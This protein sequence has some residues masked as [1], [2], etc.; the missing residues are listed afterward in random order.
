MRKDRSLLWKLLFC[1]AAIL[2]FLYLICLDY[3]NYQKNTAPHQEN[4]TTWDRQNSEKTNMD[5]TESSEIDAVTDETETDTETKENGNADKKKGRIALCLDYSRRSIYDVVFPLF[6]EK[7][8][9]GIVV[10]KQN[11]LPGGYER[12]T[13]D[14]CNELVKAGWIIALGGEKNLNL[15]ENTAETR[16]KLDEYLGKYKQAVENRVST[17]VRFFCFEENEYFEEY[18]GI[19]KAHDI[20]ALRCYEEDKI[21]GSNQTLLKFSSCKAAENTEIDGLINTLAEHVIIPGLFEPPV[22][23]LRATI[24]E[25]GSHE[26]R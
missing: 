10:F 17:K 5:V 15:K 25:N 9:T 21:S 12:L 22:R 3:P 13:S 7:N 14:Q 16:K 4:S 18:D 19:L 24:P 1:L 11:M 2:V 6:K 26:F 8:L 23:T 20:T